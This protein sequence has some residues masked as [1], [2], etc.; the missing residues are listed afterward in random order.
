[1][2]DTADG[3]LGLNLDRKLES[4]YGEVLNCR[5]DHWEKED[6]CVNVL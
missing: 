3:A 6:S 4:W 2:A 1:M 5:I